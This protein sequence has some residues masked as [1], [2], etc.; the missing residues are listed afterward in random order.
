MS[1]LR[2]LEDFF[3]WIGAVGDALAP[4]RPP[5]RALGVEDGAA[6]LLRRDGDGYS[7]ERPARAGDAAPLRLGEGEAFVAAFTLPAEAALHGRDAARIEAFRRCPFPLDGAVWTLAPAAEAWTDGAR[8][9]LA[10]APVAKVEALAARIREAGAAPGRAFALADGA[11]LDLAPGGRKRVRPLLPAAALVLLVAALAAA[12]SVEIGAGRIEAA[13]E[14]RLADARRAL[15]EAEAAAETAAE[16]RDRAAAPIRA[17]LAGDAL[18]AAAPPAAT[19]FAALTDAIPDAAH[20][21]RVAIRPGRAEID[22]IAPDVAALA[23]T[24][25]EA[26]A[27]DAAALS[28]AAR[29]DAETGLQRATL[30][31]DLAG[32]PR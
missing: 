6:V 27:F 22:V 25:A 24:L 30:K 1:A 15:T 32:A 2:R 14:A 26:D 18:L 28:G 9:R 13:A 7:V 16:R 11:P 23:R 4:P 19:A 17:A 12:A 5:A 10:A 29:A 21:R 20:A 3:S 8:W 31:V